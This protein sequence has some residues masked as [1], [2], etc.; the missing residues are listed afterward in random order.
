MTTL[1]P[2]GPSVTLTAFASL[3]T[4]RRSA[5][6]H[7]WS[8]AIFLAAMSFQILLR[9]SMDSLVIGGRVVRLWGPRRATAVPPAASDGTEGVRGRAAQGC[10][11]NRQRD[12]ARG[13]GN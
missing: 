2:F 1:R 3:L 13:S 10:L 8:N 5:A 6:R 4:P 11:P 7:S 9:V 12:R